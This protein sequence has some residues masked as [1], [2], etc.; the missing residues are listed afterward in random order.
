MPGNTKTSALNALAGSA[1]DAADYFPVLDSSASELKKLLASSVAL[2]DGGAK[3][4][5]FTA[6]PGYLYR[7]DLSTPPTSTFTAATSDVVTFA[8]L[9]PIDGMKVRVASSTTLPAGLS[10][11]TT[12]FTRDSSGSTCKLAATLDGSAI[13][14]TSTGTG[15]H[16]AT[17][18]IL[19]TFPS[20]PSVGDRFGYVLS[21]S[22]TIYDALPNRNGS[23]IMGGTD[24]QSYLL[25]IQ[26]EAVIWRYDSTSSGAGWFLEVDGRLPGQGVLQRSTGQSI[27]H[28][29]WTRITLDT[30]V[31]SVGNV[32][33]TSNNRIN[34]RRSNKYLVGI[35]VG[36]QG[37]A[38]GS[39]GVSGA[40]DF[41]AFAQVNQST[42]GSP[43]PRALQS[44]GYAPT[45]GYGSTGLDSL[46]SVISGD[47]IHLG[48]YNTSATDFYAGG[49]SVGSTL[50]VLEEL[51]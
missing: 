28:A 38:T 42:V 43:N 23:S 40:T 5:A 1:L 11:S 36:A 37:D 32:V 15:T 10:A 7:L 9:T 49:G 45:N 16:T 31:L 44:V 50:T 26:G 22:H 18:G 47:Y 41:F 46:L 20:S 34:I 13:D 6:A 12:Y 3:T 4:A 48:T 39:I 33:D 30:S 29:T 19:P 14:I 17:F 27:T 35:S 2:A 21:R 8:G 51:R 25:Y 24:P